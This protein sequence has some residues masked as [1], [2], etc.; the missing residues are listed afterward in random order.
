M[1]CVGIHCPDAWAVDTE[2]LFVRDTIELCKT[3]GFPLL[4]FEGVTYVSPELERLVALVRADE[5]EACAKVCE[6]N[7]DDLSEGD[8]DSACINCADHIRERGNT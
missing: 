2:E 7:A 6:D 3:V 4:S 1:G 8:W 5:R